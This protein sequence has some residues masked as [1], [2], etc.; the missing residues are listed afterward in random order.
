MLPLLFLWAV[1]IN[2][3]TSGLSVYSKEYIF[4][5]MYIDTYIFHI[6][7]PLLHFVSQYKL[8]LHKFINIFSLFKENDGI[9]GHLP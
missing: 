6:P 9:N 4:L 2:E 5:I 1:V 7:I 3:A 8:S